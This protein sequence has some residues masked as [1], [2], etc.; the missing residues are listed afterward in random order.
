MRASAAHDGPK[1][2]MLESIIANTRQHIE[3]QIQLVVQEP[4]TPRP[5]GLHAAVMETPVGQLCGSPCPSDPSASKYIGVFYDPKVSGQANHWPQLRVPPMR[6][7]SFKRLIEFARIRF[8]V[9]VG[10]DIPEGD[11]YLFV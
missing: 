5:H 9:E 4:D 2:E 7:E 3:A 1:R 6:Y 10:D 11:L 8:G